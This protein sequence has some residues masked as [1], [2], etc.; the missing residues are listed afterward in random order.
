MTEREQLEQTIAQLKGQRATLG[1]AVGDASIGA[2][3]DRLTALE[4]TCASKE[5]KQATVLYADVWGVG[6]PGTRTVT[7]R[8]LPLLHEREAPRC[9][10][11]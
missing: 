4:P 1:D 2:L 3:H 9:I 10:Y 8:E 11:N 6:N 5:R 7:P